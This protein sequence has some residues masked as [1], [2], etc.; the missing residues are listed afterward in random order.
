M[1]Y[2]DFVCAK[3]VWFE[4]NIFFFLSFFR[5]NCA[6]DYLVYSYYIPDHNIDSDIFVL[7]LLLDNYNTSADCYK[8]NRSGMT[9]SY[10]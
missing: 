1:K 4:V 7:L 9:L 5:V 10:I 3:L 8:F 6:Y 2:W